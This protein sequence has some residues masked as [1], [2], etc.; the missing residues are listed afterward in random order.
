ML[1]GRGGGTM[2]VVSALTRAGIYLSKH[3]PIVVSREAKRRLAW[4][5][6]CE[7]HAGNVSLTCRHFG[8]SRPTFYRWQKRY[9]PCKDPR[10]LESR[11]CVPK[12]RRKR[13]WSVAEIEAVRR[14]RRK[15]PRWGKDKL[16]VLLAREGMSLS[17]SK[18]GRIITYLKRRGALVEPKRRHKRGARR[19]QRPYAVRFDPAYKARAPGDLVQLDTLDV[20]S[21]P[22]VAFKQFTARDVFSRYDALELATTATAN[23]ATIALERMLSRLPFRVRAIQVD[24][25]SEFM[26]EFEAT[27]QRRAITL[28]ALPPRSPKLNSHAE[29]ANR[30]HSEEFYDCV[31]LPSSVAAARPFTLA[32]EHTYNHVRPH[33]A[34]GYL[35]PAEFLAQWYRLHPSTTPTCN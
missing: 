12:K 5:V 14:L 7:G 9:Y 33:Q 21:L 19:H 18:V 8:I 3:P 4:F 31:E 34:L 35:T 1:L 17:V 26:A 10:R 28:I 22:G 2:R 16:A 27:C 23:T 24:G 25:G 20:R 6:Y 29:R 32:W 30:T 13:T 15:Y 11:S